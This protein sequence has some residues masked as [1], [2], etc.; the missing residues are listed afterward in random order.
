MNKLF[1]YL[2]FNQMKSDCKAPCTQIKYTTR[3]QIKYP[4]NFTL[5]NIIFDRTIDV[6][7][8]SFS[9]NEQTLLTK[10]GGSISMGRTVLWILVSILGA[11]QVYPNSLFCFLFSVF[12]GNEQA[13]ERFVKPDIKSCV[14]SVSAFQKY[15]KINIF[16][17]LLV[18]LIRKC[19]NY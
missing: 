19:P 9:I 15:L 18:L 7:Q 17:I 8:S 5:L 4:Y 13:P 16:S 11:N 2:A 1:Y 10:L 14:A 6:T 12:E 3:P